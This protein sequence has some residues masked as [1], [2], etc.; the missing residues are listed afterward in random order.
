MSDKFVWAWNKTNEKGQMD[1]PSIQ[2]QANLHGKDQ[3]TH[4]PQNQPQL[5]SL[6]PDSVELM[7]D[8]S[9]SASRS[10]SPFTPRQTPRM[11]S[12]EMVERAQRGYEGNLTTLSTPDSPTRRHELRHYN[13]APW[14]PASPTGG[15]ARAVSAGVED[16]S[17][18]RGRRKGG[19]ETQIQ[20]VG[21]TKSRPQAQRHSIL[22]QGQKVEGDKV[23]VSGIGMRVR[24]LHMDEYGGARIV[25]R[26]P[27]PGREVKTASPF[28]RR[29]SDS[30]AKRSPES[31]PA[32]KKAW[33]KPW[34]AADQGR[35]GDT[36][37]SPRFGAAGKSVALISGSPLALAQQLKR[38]GSRSGTMVPSENVLGDAANAAIEKEAKKKVEDAELQKDAKGKSPITIKTVYPPK[39][40]SAK[41]ADK[42][43]R[44]KDDPK[45]DDDRRRKEDKDRKEKDRDKARPEGEE[46]ERRRKTK[47]DRTP[48]R[49]DYDYDYDEEPRPSKAERSRRDR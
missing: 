9:P 12:S 38:K 33:T 29:P 15:P 16:P 28:R 30:K 41:K 13:P 35:Q 4:Q 46:K 47:E 45:M 31:R 37:E 48:R 10:V 17:A 27:S 44:R 19:E 34:G 43:N 21:T 8:L 14:M 5:F 22:E 49:D 6:N 40:E 3:I 1:W 11:A 2:G 7:Q 24:D 26:A 39:A 36:P 25:W 32:N 20:K 42:D 23:T 18:W